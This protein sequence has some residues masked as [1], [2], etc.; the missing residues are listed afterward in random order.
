MRARRDEI[1]VQALVSSA[2]LAQSIASK[3]FEIDPPAL[4]L[5]RVGRE[6]VLGDWWSLAETGDVVPYVRRKIVYMVGIPRVVLA[7]TASSGKGG[8]F[9]T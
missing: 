6:I 7:H 9:A 1:D 2:V 8:E 4:F 5:R 3:I